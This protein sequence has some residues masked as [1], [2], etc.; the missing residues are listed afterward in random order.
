MKFK[1]GLV[2][3]AT[4]ACV[5]AAC[6]GGSNPSPTPTPTPSI[7]VAVDGYIQFAKVVCDLNDS[8]TVETGET[9]V[10]TRADGNFTFPNGCTH[11]I[12]VSGGRNLD[13]TNADGSV[14]A[15]G[16]FVGVLRAP[17]GAKVASPLTTLISAGMTP[18][19]ITVALGLPANTD[20]LNDDPMLNNPELLK[21]TVMVQN[22]LQ[23]ITE[24]FVKPSGTSGSLAVSAVYTEVAAAFADVLKTGAM[25]L[26]SDGTSVESVINTLVKAAGDKVLASNVVASVAPS[27]Q[28]GMNKVGSTN[29]AGALDKSLKAD[30]DK[31]LIETDP[32][33]I[34]SITLTVQANEEA[35]K[36]IDAKITAGTLTVTSTPT[37]VDAV[38]E[39]VKTAVVAGPT[40]PPAPT[41]SPTATVLASFDEATPPTITEFGGAGYDFVVATPA[42]GTGKSLK[43]TR[44]GGE[45]YAGAIV[46]TAPIPF[47]TTRKTVSAWVYS[48]VAGTPMVAKAEFAD[49][50]G[51][52]DTQATTAVVA[53]WQKLTW[54]FNNV[55]LTKSYV[56]FVILPNLGTVGTGQTYFI[57]DITLEAAASTP[58]PTPSPAAA[59]LASFDEATPPTI[60]EFG[61]AGYDFVVATPAG[62]TGKSLKL[63]RPGGEV[64]AG[65]I[66]MTAPIPFSATRKTISAWVYSPAAGTP[67]VAKAEFADQQGTGDTQPTTA[68]VAGWQ[69]LSWVFNNV[70]LTKSYTRFVILPNL[71]TVGT[72]QIY[73]IDDITL[74]AAAETPTPTPA[75]DFLYLADNAITLFNGA[76]DMGY[77]MTQFQSAA[78]INVKW[79]MADTASL[80]LNLAQNG[81]FSLGNGQTL[82]AAMQITE[83]VAGGMGEIKGYIDNVSV[84]KSGDN[85]TV[86]VPNIADA[87]LYGVSHDG[88]MKAVVNFAG[89]VAGVTNTLTAASNMVNSIILGNVVNYAING[90][91][92]DFTGMNALRGKYKVRIVVTELPLRKTDGSKFDALTIEVPTRMVDGVPGMINPVTGWGL[93]GYINLTD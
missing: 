16:P 72:G 2:P 62:G 46:M 11:G 15:G 68:V 74:E 33:K 55:D 40:Q 21:K 77:S 22:M 45:P 35:S 20:L 81:T 70:D 67:M 82:T 36:A 25:L 83:T 32:V 91:S 7:G 75:T 14:T 57:D 58:P 65:A 38:A 78:G 43:I 89:S 61:G 64:Y 47:S 87:L 80:K 31:V 17:A 24:T 84:T 44:P 76:T 54:V 29:L 79:P 37:Q 50:Q 59:V 42:G 48:P 8:G 6:G 9:T 10:Y 51:T 60:T 92:N 1:L 90:V 18:A 34:A 13:I 66:V 28:T 93:E 85:V 26:A 3:A 41:P 52:G 30:A 63:T 88:Q 23:K 56:R 19:Q 86:T 71:G 27:V 39:D 12:I 53:G 69:K 49:Q 5:L 73:Y 4:A